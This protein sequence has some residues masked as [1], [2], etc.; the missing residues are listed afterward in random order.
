MLVSQKKPFD[1]WG[2]TARLSRWV[3]CASVGLLLGNSIVQA[4]DGAQQTE[5]AGVKLGTR[6]DALG[7]KLD[8]FRAAYRYKEKYYLFGYFAKPGHPIFRIELI[9]KQARGT[10]D[11]LGIKCNDDA[12]KLVKTFGSDVEPL[13]TAEEAYDWESQSEPIYFYREKGNQF[14]RFDPA[15]K[16]I[17]GFGLAHP[18]GGWRK[19]IK[20]LTEVEISRLKLGGNAK[21]LLGKNFIS[22][23]LQMAF[24][25][26]YLTIRYD[27]KKDGNPITSISFACFDQDGRRTKAPGNDCGKTAVEL[28]SKYGVDLSA[29]CSKALGD[30]SGFY[31][32][33]TSEFWYYDSKANIVE[34]YGFSDS[35]SFEDCDVLP[36]NLTAKVRLINEAAGRK[37]HEAPLPLKSNDRVIK[38]RGIA[39]GDGV[40]SCPDVQSEVSSTERKIENV[41]TLKDGDNVTYVYFDVS[42]KYVVKIYRIAYVNDIKSY[43]NDALSFYGNDIFVKSTD[44]RSPLT[45]LEETYEFGDTSASRGLKIS[46]SKC[47][48]FDGRRNI[49]VCPVDAKY[50]VSFLMKDVGASS[51]AEK[52]GHETF[53]RK[54]F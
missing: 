15:T 7:I 37:S 16:K 42:K 40:S 54:E 19:C 23:H 30:L 8:D 53:K 35:P 10:E 36:Q 4:D 1:V 17:M 49:D 6:A 13:C 47:S 14:W 51:E 20:P 24:A 38:I 29:R 44:E 50:F 22:P 11:L 41:C 21:E 2:Y 48:Y 34:T 43:L 27:E 32:H 46:V 28:K 18:N 9:C 33:K 52:D 26:E 31:N 25:N 5:M 39:L 3:V 45:T 12:N